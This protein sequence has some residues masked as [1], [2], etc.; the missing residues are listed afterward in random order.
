[1]NDKLGSSTNLTDEGRSDIISKFTE[2]ESYFN[3]IKQ[4]IASKKPYEDVGF[5]IDE[6]LHKFEAF[7]Q[8]INLLFNAPP[9]K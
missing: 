2:M 1:M 4:T 6:V 3:V 8:T 7:K 5:D 9:P